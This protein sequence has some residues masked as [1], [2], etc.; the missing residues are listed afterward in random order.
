MWPELQIELDPDLDHL[1]LSTRTRVAV[2]S[3]CGRTGGAD[4]ASCVRP[5]LGGMS[6]KQASV[7]L[8]R[9]SV[10]GECAY[11]PGSSG[12]RRRSGA[13]GIRGGLRGSRDGSRIH[14]GRGSIVLLDGGAR[15]LSLR[16]MAG[17]FL[18]RRSIV[19]QAF[20][21]RAAAGSSTCIFTSCH[22]RGDGIAVMLEEDREVA[23]GHV[24]ELNL[25]RLAPN[26]GR[27]V[28]AHSSERTTARPGGQSTCTRR[29]RPSAARS[30]ACT[31]T[32]T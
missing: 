30:S 32:S 29:W 6:W 8:P 28:V 26:D 25:Q 9:A 14:A 12:R 2:L 24:A 1:P 3:G 10:P 27:D 19:S 13:T 5:D 22:P 16:L 31:R 21:P 4:S 17:S 11:A 20:S 15:S 23:L 7:K 18:A